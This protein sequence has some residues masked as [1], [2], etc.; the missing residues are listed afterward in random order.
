MLD[1]DQ[2]CVYDSA[3]IYCLDKS[4]AGEWEIGS[5]VIANEPLWGPN[6]GHWEE[7][8][9]VG[10]YRTV[11]VSPGTRGV[12]T[13]IRP[14][15]S[16]IHEMRESRFHDEFWHE[17]DDR[18]L[19]IKWSPRGRDLNVYPSQVLPAPPRGRK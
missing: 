3:R 17:G 8:G 13:N 4:L 19:E 18:F 16:D 6:T 2:V 1:G 15:T 14:F 9:Y 12:I 5:K 7:G 10:N 11:T